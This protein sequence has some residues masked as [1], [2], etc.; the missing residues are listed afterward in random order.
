MKNRLLHQLFPAVLSGGGAGDTTR[1]TV[2][3][4]STESSPTAA[5]KLA[6][7]ANGKRMNTAS[8]ASARERGLGKCGLC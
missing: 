2:A 6:E 8:L 7:K 3:I 1:P 5:S 4:T